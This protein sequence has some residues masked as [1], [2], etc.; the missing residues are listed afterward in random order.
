MY[1]YNTLPIHVDL[2]LNNAIVFHWF[3]RF[4]NRLKMLAFHHLNSLQSANEYSRDVCVIHQQRK[5]SAKKAAC[6]KYFW[7]NNNYYGQ[8]WW[9]RSEFEWEKQ[10]ITVYISAWDLHCKFLHSYHKELWMGDCGTFTSAVWLHEAKFSKDTL[11]RLSW[12]LYFQNAIKARIPLCEAA[13]SH[14]LSFG[15]QSLVWSQCGGASL[16]KCGP[17]RPT[18]FSHV[19]RP[20]SRSIALVR[21]L[22]EIL[23]GAARKTS[24]APFVRDHSPCR[25]V[26]DLWS[27]ECGAPPKAWTWSWSSCSTG[28]IRRCQGGVYVRKNSK[29]W[30]N[31]DGRTNG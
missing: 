16:L 13:L 19:H 21:F 17:K 30:T 4:V 3:E 24:C 9:D 22:K 7:C 2:H 29:R 11:Y 25:S 12:R 28:H 8:F 26:R 31:G 27:S 18:T 23:A 1:I 14:A 10:R 15:K 6:A 20:W 5:W